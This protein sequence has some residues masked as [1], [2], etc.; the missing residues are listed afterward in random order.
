MSQPE[1]AS[2]RIADRR[3][4]DPNAEPTITVARAA[5][6]LGISVRHA[7]AAVEREEIPAIKVGRRIAIPTARFLARC[8]L[9]DAATAA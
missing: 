3:L 7:Y 5:T 2:A 8:Q 1:P 6:I 4:P 9:S